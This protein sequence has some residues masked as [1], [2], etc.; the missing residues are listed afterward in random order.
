MDHIA[1]LAVYYAV[2]NMQHG[3]TSDQ[4]SFLG[5]SRIGDVECHCGGRRAHG[6]IE[7]YMWE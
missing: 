1:H 4:P 3:E 7:S 5:R 6:Q 2:T